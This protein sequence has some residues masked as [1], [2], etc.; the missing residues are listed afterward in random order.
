MARTNDQQNFLSQ[1]G[2]ELRDLGR[3]IGDEWHAAGVDIHNSMRRMRGSQLDY[4][5]LPIGGSLPERSEPPRSFIERQL[6]LPSPPFSM[7]RLNS[8]VHSVSDADN[9]KGIVFIFRG[10]QTGLATLQNFRRTLQRLREAGKK[11]IIFTPYLDLRHY[12]AATAA[13]RIIIPPSVHFDVLGL[14]TE[15]VFLKNTLDRLGVQAD[16]IQISPY[17]T[18][19]DSIGRAD[20]T[21]EHR[22]QLDWLLD[23][24][25]DLLTAAMADGRR[26]DQE[27]LKRLIDQAPLTA[28]EAL[29]FGLVDAVA[30]EDDLAK[31]LSGEKFGK[32][33]PDERSGESRDE[34]QPKARLKPWKEARRLLTEKARRRCSQFIG[35]ISLE[36]AIMM[37]PS[38]QP[39]IDIPIPFIGGAAAGE[40][41]LVQLLRQAEKMDDMAALIFYVNSGG[42]SALAS[43]L[44]GR[45]VS[46]LNQKKP[47]V[48]YMGDVAASGGYFVAAP[49]RHIMSQSGTITGSIGVITAHFSTRDLYQKLDVN[50]VQLARGERAG[51]YSS[52]DPLSAAE[53]QVY[54]DNIVDIYN[55]F[56]AVVAK[57]RNLP[58]ETLDPICEGRVWTGRQAEERGLVDSHGD[59]MDAIQKAAELAGLPLD[60]RHRIPV[61]D[62]HPKGGGYTP[63]VSFG[64]EAAAEINQWLSGD[65]LRTLRGPLM[66]L[67]YEI[68][69]E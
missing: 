48:V 49:A 51:L 13:D 6:P 1:L 27:E 4:I 59:F 15:I 9:V 68:R 14:H 62:I 30:Y 65:R 58:F 19:F 32:S 18:A 37:G 23:D 34:E 46:L 16:V 69:L 47:V 17:K 42:G 38:R 22:A 33:Q 43:D 40:Q 64:A 24:Q 39:P 29:E 56:K 67:P 57:G 2:R 35:V 60:N 12:F 66:L 5:V 25:F 31:L 8:I 45:Q 53:R 61:V 7:A 52:S 41:T 36:G 21:P 50:R 10:F 54:W 26:M 63:P 44:I 11:S 3:A 55:E 28:A 20:M